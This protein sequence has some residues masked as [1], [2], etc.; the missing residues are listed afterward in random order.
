M[1]VSFL[2]RSARAST[3]G[4]EARR[5]DVDVNEPQ[6]PPGNSHGG[7]GCASPGGCAAGAPEAQ[8][9]APPPRGVNSGRVSRGL[10]INS[11]GTFASLSGGKADG[12]WRAWKHNRPHGSIVLSSDPSPTM[13]RTP[14]PGAPAGQKTRFLA[15]GSATSAS[16]SAKLSVIPLTRSFSPRFLPIYSPWETVRFLPL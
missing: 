2:H 8:K 11:G 5:R 7:E 15:P 16:F 4:R 3:G 14:S 6:S 13:N 9:G 10:G 1:K 12:R